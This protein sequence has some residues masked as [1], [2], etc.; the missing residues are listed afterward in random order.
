VEMEEQDNNI[1]NGHRRALHRIHETFLHLQLNNVSH[2]EKG[3]P[4][5]TNKT[6]ETIMSP[7][8]VVI[9]PQ[10][11]RNTQRLLKVAKD[12]NIDIRPHVKTHKTLEGARFQTAGQKHPKIVVSTLSEA[13][14]FAEGGFRDILYGMPIPKRKLPVAAQILKK[15]TCC[16]YSLIILYTLKILL[17]ME[18]RTT[19][20]GQ[21]LS[22]LILDI[23]D[24]V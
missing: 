24:M 12:R 9:E 18:R 19:S 10:L 8:F 13:K 14:F 7:A 23:T 17:H 20:D 2:E 15:L 21:C 22:K 4:V 3:K 6:L 11:K 16:T 5:D 1:E